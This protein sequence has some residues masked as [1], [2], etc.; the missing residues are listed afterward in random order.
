MKR[1]LALICVTLIIPFSASAQTVSPSCPIN[2]PAKDVGI[3]LKSASSN[4]FLGGTNV[5]CV[6]HAPNGFQAANKSI[7]LSVKCPNGF[8]VEIPGYVQSGGLV[9][10]FAFLATEFSDGKSGADVGIVT[11][12]AAASWNIQVKALCR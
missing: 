2:D 7:S 6:Y 4:S 11:S 3:E 10:V 9:P 8:R 1:L 5:T 12:S